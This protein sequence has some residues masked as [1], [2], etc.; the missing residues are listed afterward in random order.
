MKAAPTESLL[1]VNFIPEV[2]DLQ[3]QGIIEKAHVT[4]PTDWV[5]APTIVNKPSAKNGLCID[6][7]PLNTAPKRSEYSIPISEV[8]LLAC[9]TGRTQFPTQ[10]LQH[11][12]WKNQIEQGAFWH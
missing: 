5:S 4:E 10:N 12:C 2:K 1:S 7:R 3:E 6:S 9:P 11:S 8:G